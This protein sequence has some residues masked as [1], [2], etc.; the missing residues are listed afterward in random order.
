MNNIQI[1]SKIYIL[2][3]IYNISLYIEIKYNS[4]AN[5]AIKKRC[6]YYK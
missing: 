6:N 1:K 3:K 4:K 2:L 5:Y